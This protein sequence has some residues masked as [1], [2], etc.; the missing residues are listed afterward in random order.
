MHHTFD[1]QIF[2]GQ[3]MR[4]ARCGENDFSVIVAGHAAGRIFE[5][6]RGSGKCVWLWTMTG[7]YLPGAGLTGSGDSDDLPA[8]KAAFRATFDAWLAWTIRQNAPV[9]WYE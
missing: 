2:V 4:L 1:P 3:P 6:M 9:T 5:T 7:P 8:A